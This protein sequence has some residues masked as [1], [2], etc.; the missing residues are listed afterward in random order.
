MIIDHIQV[1]DICPS[2]R[3]RG[4]FQVKS[5]LT[6]TISSLS[7]TIVNVSSTS[8]IWRKFMSCFTMYSVIWINSLRGVGTRMGGVP[9]VDN[10]LSQK[11]KELC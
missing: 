1:T 10:S 3:V 2:L 4:I 6:K 9:M 7:A 11:R 5:L 8:S